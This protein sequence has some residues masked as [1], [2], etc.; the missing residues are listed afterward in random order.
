MIFYCLG[1]F[2]CPYTDNIQINTSEIKKIRFFLHFFCNTLKHSEK[3]L[4]CWVQSASVGG[5]MLIYIYYLFPFLRV[6]L[7]VSS[8][9]NAAS[10][11]ARVETFN[12][13]LPNSN[14][15]MLEN[16]TPVTSPK[17]R[18]DKPFCRRKSCMYFPQSITPAKLQKISTRHAAQQVGSEQ[19]RTRPAGQKKRHYKYCSAFAMRKTATRLNNG[20]NFAPFQSFAPIV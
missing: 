8:Y 6:G 16:G 10:R 3:K 12:S 5:C 4:F 20:G 13:F 18:S 11:R 1:R 2:P 19:A 7:A 15:P 14:A 9:P 17:S